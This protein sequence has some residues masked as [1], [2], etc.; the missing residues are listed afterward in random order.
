MQTTNKCSYASVPKDD[1]PTVDRKPYQPPLV[2]ELGSIS[3]LT[4]STSVD[5]NIS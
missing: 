2:Q 3:E 5:F 1:E 4:F